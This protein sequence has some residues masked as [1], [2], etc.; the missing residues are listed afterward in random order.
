MNYIVLRGEYFYNSKRR[1]RAV[2]KL[3]AAHTTLRRF[4]PRR[5]ADDETN[6]L[7]LTWS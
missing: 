4:Q 6:G 3:K 2:T 1:N 7:R 5:S